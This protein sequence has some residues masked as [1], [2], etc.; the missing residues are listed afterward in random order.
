MKSLTVLSTTM[1]VTLFILST[2]CSNP[3]KVSKRP[4]KKKDSI[5][6]GRFTPQELG[7]K[8]KWNRSAFFGGS[9]KCFGKFDEKIFAVDNK[10]GFY[11]FK[12]PKQTDLEQKYGQPF[13]TLYLVCRYDYGDY[14][15][16]SNIKITEK[17]FAYSTGNALIIPELIF[18]Y[19]NKKKHFPAEMKVVTSL[20]SLKTIKSQFEKEYPKRVPGIEYSIMGIS[21]KMNHVDI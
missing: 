7:K 2:G 9:R 20:E 15:Y 19:T 12:L 6:M 5:V 16:F 17:R 8:S 18:D 11:A 13:K 3:I 10:T 1:F 14:I 4:P 21:E